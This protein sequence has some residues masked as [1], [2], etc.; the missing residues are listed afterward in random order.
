M[1]RKIKSDLP[2]NLK[3][4]F[5]RATVETALMFGAN[6]WALNKTHESTL[7]GTYT[8]MLRRHP[9]KLQL[10]GPIPDILTILRERRM[11]IVGHCCWPK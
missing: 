6:A 4:S 1:S 2:D 8:R 3:R 7:D 5:F 9:T 11:R 10:Y